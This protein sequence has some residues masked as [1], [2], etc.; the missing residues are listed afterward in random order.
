MG[1]ILSAMA[2]AGDAGVQSENQ[3]ITQMNASD[4]DKERAALEVEKDKT[5]SDNL[6]SQKDAPLNRF[7]KAVQDNLGAQVPV[8]PGAA[9]TAAAAPA[10]APAITAPTSNQTGNPLVDSVAAKEGLSPM[11]AKAM[12]ALLGQ[13]SNN[14]KNAATS[15]D[16]AIGVGQIMPATFAQYAK[17]GESISNQAD[18]LAVMARIVKGLGVQSGD[19]PAKIAAGY[20]SGPGNMNLADD[21]KTPWINN[22]SDGNGKSVSS[23]VGD[24]MGRM[25]PTDSAP[26]Q[27]ASNDDS[28]QGNQIQLGGSSPSASDAATGQTRNMTQSEAISAALSSMKTSDLPAYVAA[29]AALGDK[30]MSV[31]DGAMLVDPNTGKVVI[32]NTGKQ[33]AAALL[34][35]QTEARAQMMEDGRNARQLA[36]L[37]AQNTTDTQFT[38]E[39]KQLYPEGSADYN[40]ALRQRINKETGIAGPAGGRSTVY[41]G[42]I[43]ASGNEIASALSNIT[44]LPVETNTGF[45]GSGKPTSNG[46]LSS[47]LAGL[48][49]E[50][51]SDQVKT[52]NTMWTGVARNL[53]T[54][55]T[56]GLATTTGLVSSIDKLS[57]VPGDNGY[58]ALRKL[59][60]V[61]QITE[62][63]LDP[64]LEDP[65]VPPQQKQFIQGV[66]DKVKAAVPYTHADLTNFKNAQDANPSMTF[67]D[68]AKQTL[69]T[70]SPSQSTSNTASAWSNLRIAN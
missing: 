47:G 10:I 16:G 32:S 34:A 48:K 57:F 1:I 21:A 15:T 54:L 52:Y 2:A 50:L 30:F 44:A 4:M 46:L 62:A 20:F 56:S 35:T 19:D 64:K 66:L 40:E 59:A 31:A 69:G 28:Q 63:A 43:I 5:I 26:T 65:S 58:N 70:Q 68:F 6:Q 49:N 41:N 25:G 39:L 12:S 29:K 42:R 51:N 11:Q 3:N 37:S 45:L 61:R 14:G 27:L 17:N 7:T 22:P 67:T 9:A 18:N 33:D 13:E 60:E 23:Y 38:K 53:G 55:E 24:V 8:T 36:V